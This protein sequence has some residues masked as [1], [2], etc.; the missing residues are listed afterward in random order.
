MKIA[1]N[2]LNAFVQWV[3]QHAID[4]TYIRFRQLEECIEINVPS[5]DEAILVKLRWS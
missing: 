4:V 3:R 5:V 2:D 1:Y